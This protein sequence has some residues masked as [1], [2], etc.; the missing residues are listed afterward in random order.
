ML[1]LYLKK[2]GRKRETE[3]GEVLEGCLGLTSIK[4][5]L[6]GLKETEKSTFS[7]YGLILLPIECST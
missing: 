3:R 1:L 6:L 2:G 5:R 7:F 4:V